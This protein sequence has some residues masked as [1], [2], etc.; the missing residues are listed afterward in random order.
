MGAST[1]L[2]SSGSLES[3]PTGLVASE[4]EVPN[5]VMVRPAV[6]PFRPSIMVIPTKKSPEGLSF[7]SRAVVPAMF[8]CTTPLTLISYSEPVQDTSRVL[9]S[10]P[11]SSSSAVV[12]TPAF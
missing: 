8:A 4:A 3:E 5:L 11:S 6:P 7:S 2:F 12:G 9:I 1:R 10:R